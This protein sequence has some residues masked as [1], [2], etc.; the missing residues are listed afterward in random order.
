VNYLMSQP[1]FR[2]DPRREMTDFM[3]AVD[4]MR[5]DDTDEWLRK[6]FSQFRRV[7]ADAVRP[8]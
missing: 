2:A 6:P 5:F 3:A 4:A 1:S 8:R 7:M